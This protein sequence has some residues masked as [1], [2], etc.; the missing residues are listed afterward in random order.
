[1]EDLELEVLR[2]DRTGRAACLLV[3]AFAEPATS[4]SEA[5]ALAARLA[6]ILG[7]TLRK[8]DLG[9]RIGA[10]E[11]A[12]L[13]PETRA[14]GAVVAASRLQ[15]ALSLGDVVEIV[16]GIAE[17]GPGIAPNLL[18]RNAYRALLAAANMSRPAV[19]VYSPELD[20]RGDGAVRG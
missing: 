16:G 19:L 13:L 7:T 18:F 10:G 8:I 12:I 1:M 14:T 11:F 15:Q 17:A 6:D 4:E 5:D 3:L 9:Y 2:G 20:P